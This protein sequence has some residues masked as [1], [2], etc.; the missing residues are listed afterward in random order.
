MPP[1]DR[2]PPDT[3]PIR[4]P[5]RMRF[6]SAG[7]LVGRQIRQAG[8]SR[9]FAVARVLT[10][11]AEVAGPEL[12]NLCRPVR[13]SYAKKGFGATLVVEAPGAAAPLVSM[14]LDALRARINAVYGY[15]AIARV[16][17]VQGAGL[18]LVPGMAEGQTPFAG[19]R[20]A[21]RADNLAVPSPAAL[22]RARGVVAAM[23]EG[24][25]DEGLRSALERLA[26]NVLG[27]TAPRAPGPATD[28]KDT[29]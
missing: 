1:P 25:A 4:A 24:V 2:E 13:V 21:L 7:A 10:H 18:S 26:Q 16:Q 27:R 29:A 28:G 19:A 5:R 3:G 8:E 12:A 22:T 17:L 6:E 23:T 9:G 20:P 15:A 14:R 11:W